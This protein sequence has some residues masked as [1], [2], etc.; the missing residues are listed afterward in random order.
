VML[1][2]AKDPSWRP[3]TAGE[4]ADQA[5]RLRDRLVSGTIASRP[6]RVDAPLASADSPG[7]RTGGAVRSRTRPGRAQRQRILG[8]ALVALSALACL[9]LLTATG[10]ASASRPAAPL[11]SGP[12]QAAPAVTKSPSTASSAAARSAGQ[13]P[14]TTSDVSTGAVAAVRHTP[15]RYPRSQPGSPR[16]KHGPHPGHGPGPGPRKRRATV[17]AA[18]GSVS[19]AG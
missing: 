17:L 18:A 9:A 12:P 10:L 14:S 7:S 19:G 4:V 15:G 16:S 1:L 6:V 8:I 13:Q 11:S 2:T 5:R 3:A